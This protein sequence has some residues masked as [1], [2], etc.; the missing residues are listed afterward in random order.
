MRAI[1]AQM[2]QN[3]AP[4]LS[5]TQ[6]RVLAF[7]D[8]NPGASLSAVAEYIGVTLPSMS[9][10]IDGLVEQKLVVRESNAADRRRMTLAL[11]ARGRTWLNSARSRAETHLA[12]LFRELSEP[13]CAGILQAMTALRPIFTQE[14]ASVFENTK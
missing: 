12:R 4:T 5:V 8:T 14:R 13:Q 10:M 1:R 11:S 3:R 6:F 7:L 9:K 2:R